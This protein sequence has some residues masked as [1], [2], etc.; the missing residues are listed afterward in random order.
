MAGS[1]LFSKMLFPPDCI[2]KFESGEA[3]HLHQ[4]FHWVISEWL[5]F[6]VEIGVPSVK[7]HTVHFKSRY[8]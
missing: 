5:S 4:I 2:D 1:P 3:G 6:A 8:S 7:K